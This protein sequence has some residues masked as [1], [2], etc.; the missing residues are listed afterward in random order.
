LHTEDPQ[1]LVAWATWNQGFVHPWLSACY[2]GNFSILNYVAKMLQLCMPTFSAGVKAGAVC[3][4]WLQ[5][6]RVSSF[7]WTLL[8]HCTWIICVNLLC[9]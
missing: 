8:I 6:Y 5:F 1:N 2:F 7:S 3:N 9:K 4:F